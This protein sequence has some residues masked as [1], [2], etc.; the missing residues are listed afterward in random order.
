MNI[1]LLKLPRTGSTYLGELLD[2]HS[3]I[4]FANEF[5]NPFSQKQRLLSRG[6]LNHIKLDRPFRA[7]IQKKKCAALQGYLSCSSQ[8]CVHGASLNPFK[9]RL[10]AHDLAKLITDESRVIVLVRN[11]L[12]KQ[13][14]SALNVLAE[15]R[16][17]AIN[18]HQPYGGSP[19]S[20]ERRFVI[21]LRDLESIGHLEQRRGRL[22]DLANSIDRP[23]LVLTYEDDIN[24]PDRNL[25]TDKLADFLQLDIN[26]GWKWGGAIKHVSGP[27]R[28]LVSDDL[29]AV[30][31]N[32]DEVRTW[33]QLQ[34]YL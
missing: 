24:I 27:F 25:L 33:P 32:F 21:G 31:E 12:L 14:V 1:L 22:L 30:I 11:N 17:G 16:S 5:L 4:R 6:L 29:E 3:R 26:D 28:K 20:T 34:P 23:K 18:P 9:E 2:S 13:H 8:R 19:G 7:H 15:K 10:N